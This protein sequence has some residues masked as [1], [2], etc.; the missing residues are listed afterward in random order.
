[1]QALV[2]S[3]FHNGSQKPNTDQLAGQLS[4]PI[5]IT[6]EREEKTEIV[7]VV[8]TPAVAAAPPTSGF[9][10]IHA[11]AV[12]ACSNYVFPQALVALLAGYLWA[13]YTGEKDLQD[14]A[15]VV[16]RVLLVLCVLTRL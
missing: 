7:T 12:H 14:Q 10:A 5:V 6:E 15:D 3:L 13:R 2:G 11:R 9:A 1:M 16:F 4:E 8:R